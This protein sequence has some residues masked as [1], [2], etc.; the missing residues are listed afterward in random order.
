MPRM[1]KRETSCKRQLWI[2]VNRRMPDSG[3][4]DS[5]SSADLRPY[6]SVATKLKISQKN[7][8]RFIF[9]YDAKVMSLAKTSFR[10]R[11]AVPSGFS[12]RVG[13]VSTLVWDYAM[14]KQYELLVQL[15]L[16]T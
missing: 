11:T 2:Q 15:C 6:P 5:D 14:H 8:E 7:S 3:E 13:T 10:T 1:A 16:Y 9:I 4:L 12:L